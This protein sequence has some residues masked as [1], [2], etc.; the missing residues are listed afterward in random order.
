MKRTDFTAH[1]PCQDGKRWTDEVPVDE[2]RKEPTLL[3]FI[4]TFVQRQVNRML[5]GCRFSVNCSA[6]IQGCNLLTSTWSQ[7]GQL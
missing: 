7:A 6:K 3:P 5:A 1:P 2:H 4:V